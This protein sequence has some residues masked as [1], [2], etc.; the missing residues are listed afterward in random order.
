M[1]EKDMAAPEA[2][3]AAPQP[4]K[5]GNGQAGPPSASPAAAHNEMGAEF[6]KMGRLEAASDCYRRAVAL[7]PEDAESHNNLGTVLAKM[8]RAEEARTCFE[9]VLAINPRHANAL[10]N[11]GIVV[12]QLGEHQNAI[13]FY[14]RALTIRPDHANAYQNMGNAFMKLDQPQQ[15]AEAYRKCLEIIP[16]HYRVQYSLGTALAQM[17]KL[18]DAIECYKGV[19]EMNPG[20][21]EAHHGIG[22]CLQQLGKI[23]EAAKHFEK[24]L[25]LKPDFAPAYDS[26]A[27]QKKIDDEGATAESLE[28]LLARKNLPEG[29]RCAAHYA[30]GRVYEESGDYDKSFEHYRQGNAMMKEEFDP[31]KHAE[32]VSSILEV[33]TPALFERFKGLGDPTTKPIF[34]VG[35]IRSGT[36]LTE[37]IISSH[38]QVYGAGELETIKNIALAIP[39]AVKSGKAFPYCVADMTGETIKQAAK[40]YYDDITAMSDGSPF[41]TDK[42]P[43]NFFHVGLIEILFP[44]AR[45]LHTRRN[46]LD[47]C[48][49]AYFNKFQTGQQFSYDLTHLGKYYREYVRLMDHWR[50]VLPK[51]MLEVQYEEL[52]SNQEETSRKIIEFCG[53]PWDDK[54]LE[55]HKNERPIRTASSWQVRQPMYSS[56]VDRWRPYVSHLKP[57]IDALGDLA[58]V[59]KQAAKGKAGARA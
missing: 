34:I 39:R 7:A 24:A 1:D 37:Q 11:L 10:N 49:S 17:G 14:R 44:N 48:L 32:F 51:P 6:E 55:F 35:M 12:S 9:K 36:T 57:L 59:D 50:K 43:G 29:E 5:P 42:M 3:P 22:N 58:P 21:V 19:L 28:A 41:V 15:A 23:D 2:S 8:G 26:L 56:S 20:F 47:N 46:P 27:R 13:A 54:C 4:A 18:D 53:L 25:A 33:F 38:P 40:K 30:L 45:I 52:V 16:R 31:R